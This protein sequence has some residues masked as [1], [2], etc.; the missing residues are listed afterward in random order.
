MK[1][2]LNILHQFMAQN[3]FGEIFIDKL[4]CDMIAIVRHSTVTHE[5]IVLVSRLVSCINE[6]FFLTFLS[7]FGEA[8]IAEYKFLVL[9]CSAEF[10]K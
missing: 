9:M 7:H 2:E 5:A 3:D 8:T 10:K 1:R 4:G 6:L